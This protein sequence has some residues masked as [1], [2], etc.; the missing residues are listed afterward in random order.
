MASCG[1]KCAE[2]CPGRERE[3]PLWGAVPAS[4]G[5]GAA[6]PVGGTRGCVK[7]PPPCWAPQRALRLVS[8][9]SCAGTPPPSQE[10]PRLQNLGGNIP[11]GAVV[12]LLPCPAASSSRRPAEAPTFVCTSQGG[13]W[14]IA[15]S[16]ASITNPTGFCSSPFSQSSGQKSYL[17]ALMATVVVASAFIDHQLGFLVGLVCFLASKYTSRF[18][19]TI[20]VILFCQNRY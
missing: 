8:P 11:G 3:P 1:Q 5:C 14:Y 19:I 12:R 13:L 20:C 2:T 10:V 4:R 7:C 17:Y 6:A 16:L 18:G 9:L 15:E